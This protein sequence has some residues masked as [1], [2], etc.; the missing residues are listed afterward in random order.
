M[1]LFDTVILSCDSHSGFL[2]YVPMVT[3][4]WKKLF[5]CNV[6]L[7]VLGE[8]DSL[9]YS[10]VDSIYKFPLIKDISVQCQSKLLRSYLASVL[11]GNEVYLINDIDMVPLATYYLEERLSQRNKMELCFITCDKFYEE[12]SLKNK[13][14]IAN[15]TGEGYLFNELHKYADFQNFESFVKSFIGFGP[16]FDNLEDTSNPEFSHESLVRALLYGIPNSLNIKLIPGEV[17]PFSDRIID[18]ADWKYDKVKLYNKY[19]YASHM[20]RPYNVKELKD[21]IEYVDSI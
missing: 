8:N 16:Y 18:R 17:Y 11:D 19:Y 1:K 4:A 3:K 6:I 12:P 15:T 5:G 2:D 7:G 21:I 20:P 9:N 14:P 10:Y 13:Y